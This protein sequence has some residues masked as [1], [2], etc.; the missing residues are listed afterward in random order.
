[1]L[2]NK[3]YHH[4]I[5][6]IHHKTFDVDGYYPLILPTLD[7]L[8]LKS[9][10]SLASWKFYTQSLLHNKQKNFSPLVLFSQE[11][12]NYQSCLQKK[13]N[14]P[15]FAKK[16]RIS[17]TQI[18]NL[19]KSDQSLKVFLG[20]HQT[21]SFSSL[22]SSKIQEICDL[23]SE[24]KLWKYTPQLVYRD[25][26][27]QTPVHAEH[28]IWKEEE[29]PLLQIK[30]FVEAKGEVL[31]LVVD[32]LTTFF[33]DVA[34][35]VHNNDKRYKKFIGKNI[36]LPIINKKIPI[37]WADGVDTLKNNGIVRINPLLSPQHLKKVKE[38]W[39]PID[40]NIID[41][42]GNLQE[43]FVQKAV[44]SNEKKSENI[45][46]KYNI[47]QNI[48]NIILGLKEIGNLA[49]ETT[50]V[51]K[52]AYSTLSGKRLLKKVLPQLTL[53]YTELA[54]DFFAW[55]Q[56]NYGENLSKQFSQ[57]ETKILAQ[58]NNPYGQ[59]FAYKEEKI[60]YT[61]ASLVN[62]TKP[63]PFLLASLLL[64]WKIKETLAFNDLID[65]CFLIPEH[66]LQL[67][68]E[69]FWKK[70]IFLRAI[71][72]FKQASEEEQITSLLN[73][74]NQ[75]PGIKLS[76]DQLSLLFIKENFLSNTSPLLWVR[77]EQILDTF[78]ISLLRDQLKKPFA[79]AL[80]THQQI[81]TILLL[82][83]F[84]KG[85]HKEYEFIDV[86]FWFWKNLWTEKTLTQIQEY[87]RD[88][89][90]WLFAQQIKP[91][92]ESLDQ[93]YNYHNHLRNLFKRLYEHN[94][95][96]QS[97]ASATALDLWIFEQFTVLK[98]LAQNNEK[99]WSASLFIS[100]V[101]DFTK[102]D[103]SR[104][105]ECIKKLDIYWDYHIAG[106]IFLEL[107]ELLGPY[108]TEM[109]EQIL[110]LV[111]KDSQCHSNLNLSC[112]KDFKIYKLF[113]LIHKIS[114]KKSELKLKKHQKITLFH[115]GS[116]ETFNLL[117]ENQTV[118]SSLLS[119]DQI[120][121]SERNEPI[122][123]NF[124]S[125]KLLDGEL[126][127]ADATSECKKDELSELE[128]QYHDKQTYLQT[129]KDVL[130][131]LNSSPLADPLKVEEKEDEYAMIKDQLLTLEIKIQ[132]LKMQKKS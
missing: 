72:E 24:K 12:Q 80:N 19:K 9:R 27:Y 131:M 110:H 55:I 16:Q 120:L 96:E 90:T 127:V 65:L 66:D 123:R 122:P 91:D 119:V 113:D 62:K 48:D 51:Q 116:Q 56:E 5:W 93:T 88:T 75:D 8:S 118:L 132:K 99:N 71:E 30:C 20:E 1:M 7:P 108:L 67:I 52:V 4:K 58:V 83:D 103:F 95:F 60:F 68:G 106:T 40:E 25:T 78:A 112:P 57:F 10:E 121:M 114:E 92:Q 23:F 53:D 128:K 130:I 15:F 74:E 49:E 26:Y 82:I 104:Y 2:I 39:L 87:G 101:Q 105:L 98:D 86:N 3:K 17:H 107:I 33:S 84:L 28:I 126:G 102:K 61:P 94:A 64:E 34:V 79:L 36:I 124:S 125:F 77:D 6:K 32:D 115:K 73:L 109:R 29:Q 42:N 46:I 18:R 13:T 117:L 85:K 54:E 35:V 11:T 70:E 38:L 31:T 22:N 129:V 14:L 97:N 76:P 59:Y 50:Q 47:L 21:F 63:L 41:E 43:D 69:A 44:V 81:Q 89:I 111:R 45:G 37:L 100:R